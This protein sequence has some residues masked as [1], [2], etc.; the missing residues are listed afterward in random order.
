VTT[1]PGFVLQSDWGREWL[2]NQAAGLQS[3]AASRHLYETVLRKF[4]VSLNN[5]KVHTA[6]AVDGLEYDANLERVTGMP[7]SLPM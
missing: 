6:A 5:L 7:L 1:V 2:P 3:L 4:V